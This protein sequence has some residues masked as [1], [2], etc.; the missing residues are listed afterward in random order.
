[1]IGDNSRELSLVEQLSE[2]VQQ[3]ADWLKGR[4]I[5]DKTTADQAANRRAEVLRLKGL[6][7]KEWDAAALPHD[8]ALS[9]LKSLYDAPVKTAE[10]VNK[11]LRD[12]ATAF[13]KAEED[14]LKAEQAAKYEAERRAVEAAR[15][16]AEAER[17]KIIRDDPIAALTSPEPELPMAP[18]PP[19]PVKLSLGGQAGKSAGLRSY[20]EAEITDHAAA[21]AH[22]AN[23]P[24]VIALIQKL[25]KADVKASKGTAKIPGVRG[26]EDRRVA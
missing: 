25:A 5:A 21:L 4:K 8:K 23:H 13:A 24:D 18:P 15:K 16:A 17:A 22:Y 11:A 1:M 7:E 2:Y 6:V 10:A 14:R 9:E 3:T 19:E 12:A 20:W 26:Y